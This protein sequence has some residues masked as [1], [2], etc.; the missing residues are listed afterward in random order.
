M[1]PQWWW[2]DGHGDGRVG[3]SGAQ[4]DGREIGRTQGLGRWGRRGAGQV[5]WDLGPYQGLQLKAQGPAEEVVTEL[6]VGWLQQWLWMS[7][8][9]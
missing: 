1:A 7:L 9:W 6:E 3:R 8:P 2:S 4:E 5:T